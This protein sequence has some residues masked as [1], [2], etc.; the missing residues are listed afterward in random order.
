MLGHLTACLPP[1]VESGLDWF[2][3][4]TFFFFFFFFLRATPAAYRASQARGQIE[5]A[6]LH[7]SHSNIGSKLHL[8]P[9]P[10]LMALPDP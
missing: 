5:V 8:Q 9:T 2:S 3:Q 7:H 1:G 6:S 4:V 10:Q